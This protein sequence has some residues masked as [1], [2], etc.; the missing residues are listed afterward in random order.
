MGIVTYG[1]KELEIYNRNNET[2]DARAQ[3]KSDF[4]FAALLQL[5]YSP[6]QKKKNTRVLYAVTVHQINIR[7]MKNRTKQMIEIDFYC[8]IVVDTEIVYCTNTYNDFILLF[9]PFP[10]F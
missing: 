1:L 10:K 9:L 8:V 7:E 3:S 6:F 5:S 4:A 2:K